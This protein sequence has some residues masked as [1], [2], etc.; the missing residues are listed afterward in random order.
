MC[1]SNYYIE[2]LILLLHDQY[3]I[4]LVIAHPSDEMDS[5]FFE[6]RDLFTV[7]IDNID[8]F[9]NNCCVWL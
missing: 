8:L 9:D 1:L 2:G 5:H 3:K 4:I 7:K 6:R